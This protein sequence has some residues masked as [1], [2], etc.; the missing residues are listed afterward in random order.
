MW[1]L[2]ARG[3]IPAV[4]RETVSL[5]RRIERALETIAHGSHP[6]ETIQQT[7]QRLVED[8]ADDLGI[9]GGR[10]YEQ[11]NS[12]YTLVRTFGE[13]TKAPVGL[14]IS[15]YYAAFEQL[16]DVGSLVMGRDD[17]SLDQRLEAD[18]GTRDHFAAVAVADGDYVLSFDVEA[19]EDRRDELIS[20]LN[21]LRL[22]INQKLREERVKAI[23][24]DARLIQHSILPRRLPS[25]GDYRIGARTVPAEIVGGD[26][27]DVITITDT[28][29]AAVLADAT[30]HGL[31]AALQ[32]R[33]IYTGLRMGLSRE[34]K[35]SRT[36]ERLNQ[37]IHRS[38]MA[39]KFVSLF[40]AE[41]EIGG[42]VIYCNAGHPPALLIRS[43][44]EVEHL[45]TGGMILGPRPNARYAID[46]VRLEPGDGL[47]LYSDG[48]TEA[49]HHAS[50][51]EF[52]LER[53]TEVVR[54]HRHAGPDAVINGV[55]AAVAAHSRQGAPEDDQ[56]MLVITRQTAPETES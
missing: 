40:L 6:L 34:Y 24:E 9:R 28:T 43:G 52:G 48:L 51:E 29:F 54:R 22:A 55:F 2:E 31:P 13:V 16:L 26:F 56:T 53:L 41:L 37:I 39:T 14:R 1:N 47:V 45:S 7:A 21:I 4:S 36:L 17:P 10:I 18:L 3:K 46:L 50:G 33:D 25:Y 5:F 44:G 23:L 20:T 19:F 12:H 49:N 11:E 38:R 35:L 42:T 32:V 27:Y 15:R 30:G 8:F